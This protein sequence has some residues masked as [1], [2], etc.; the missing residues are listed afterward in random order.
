MGVVEIYFT[1][2]PWPTSVTADYVE[3]GD[4]EICEGDKVIAKIS[5]VMAVAMSL[6]LRHAAKAG[7]A[8]LRKTLAVRS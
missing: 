7:L 2:N 4:I 5:P 8:D 3:S 1:D 6:M